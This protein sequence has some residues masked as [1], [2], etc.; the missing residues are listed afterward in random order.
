MIN[1]ILFNKSHHKNTSCY[2][3]SIEYFS[4]LCFKNENVEY[5]TF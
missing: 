1:K 2:E 5:S 4:D 3:R